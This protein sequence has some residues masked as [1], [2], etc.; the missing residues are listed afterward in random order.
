MDWDAIGAI[1]EVVGAV[2][3][4]AT[5]FYFSLQ[6]R[7]STLAQRASTN[8]AIWAEWRQ[9]QRETYIGRSDNIELYVRGLKNFDGLSGAEKRR[10]NFVLS[11]EWLF[12]E[13]VIKQYQFGNVDEE[14][15]AG[16][17][18]FFVSQI[19]APGGAQWWAQSKSAF[20]PASVEVFEAFAAQMGE[21]PS[22]FQDVA[23]FDPDID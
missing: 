7:N 21:Q 1:G 8:S 12:I 13:N 10:F 3:V 20:L 2:A 9:H 19:R 16:W 23:Y 6:I 22:I 15:Y 18:G 17:L 5:L 11:S 14:D 4:V